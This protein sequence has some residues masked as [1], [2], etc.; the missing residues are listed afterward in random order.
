[1]P[2]AFQEIPTEFVS[3]SSIV[4]YKT[5]ITQVLSDVRKYGAVVVTKDGKYL[6]LVDD[7]AIA[8]SVGTNMNE[9]A[10]IGKVAKTGQVLGQNTSVRDAISFF[11]NSATK[12]LPYLKDGKII[13]IVKRDTILKAVLS[14][15]LLQNVSVKEI[16]STPLLSIDADMNLAQARSMMENDNISRLIVMSKNK[17]Y[18]L[19]TYK[20]IINYS[21]RLEERNQ[22]GKSSLESNMKI[23]DVCEKN[24]YMIEREKSVEDAIRSLVEHNISAVVV[25]KDN[26]P[27]G[28][29]TVKDILEAA[30]GSQGTAHENII[31]SG[32][33]ESSAEYRDDISNSLKEIAE[34]VDRFGRFKVSAIS[35]NFKRVKTKGYEIRARIELEKGVPIFAEADGYTLEKTLGDLEEK[36]YKEIKEKKNMDVTTKKE[37]GAPNE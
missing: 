29:V 17:F 13:G 1:M 12:A 22:K 3:K 25:T 30:N 5:P 18:G 26:A 10:S 19:L 21:T 14:L 23:S 2:V 35:V 15:H 27:I 24:V 11:Y 31:I 9:G 20:N 7:R 28:I 8:R 33:D 16:M 36:L 34:K 6:G 4:D 32:L 37:L